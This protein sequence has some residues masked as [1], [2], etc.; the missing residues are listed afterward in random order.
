M[1][2]SSTPP[3]ARPQIGGDIGSAA[4]ARRRALTR[5][6]YGLAGLAA[7]GAGVWGWRQQSAVSVSK[8][9][10]PHLNIA[11]LQALDGSAFDAQAFVGQRPVLLNF[12]APWCPPCV[13][14][15]PLI[16]GQYAAISSE[17][18]QTQAQAPFALLAVALDD[19][20]PVQRFWQQRQLPA[21]TPVVA[22]YAGM[23]WMKALGN[24]T[25]QLPYS[26]LL[27]AD[28]AILQQHLGALEAGDIT[29]IFALAQ[30]HVR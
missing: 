14:E 21:I 23:A 5:L 20:A 24:S 2:H 27:G 12:W 3:S 17:H 25:G 6:G 30:Q 7:M 1:T 9:H 29:R 11:H 16:A 4:P 15:L 19:L 22:G 18:G 28:G 8:M 10:N 26:V 13:Q